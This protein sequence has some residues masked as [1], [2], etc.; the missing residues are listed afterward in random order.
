MISSVPGVYMTLLPLFWSR[1][2]TLVDLAG[3]DA[4]KVE[5]GVQ[6]ASLAPVPTPL[7]A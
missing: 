4:S 7:K 1:Y 5:P 2:R 6:G 3:L